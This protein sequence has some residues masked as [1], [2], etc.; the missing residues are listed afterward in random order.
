MPLRSQRAKKRNNAIVRAVKG[1]FL[2][3]L[4]MIVIRKATTPRITP[5]QKISYSFDN[6]YIGD[7]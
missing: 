1:T 6:L 5:S 3:L 7:Y 4:A 2:R